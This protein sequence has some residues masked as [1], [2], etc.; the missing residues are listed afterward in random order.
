MEATFP[1]ATV[2][3]Q[4]YSFNYTNITAI[5]GHKYVFSF[6]IQTSGLAANGGKINI[7]YGYY[8]PT[9]VYGLVN[10]IADGIIYLDFVCPTN[11]KQFNPG[12]VVYPTT[13]P[14]SIMVKMAQV[15]LYDI[16]A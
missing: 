14:Q 6:R 9:V 7:A 1:P 10:D 3:G 12:I 13:N 2:S 11:V 8:G 5:P 16:G 15:G 4:S